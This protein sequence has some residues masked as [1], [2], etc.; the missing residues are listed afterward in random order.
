MHEFLDQ[1]AAS[2]DSAGKKAILGA[3]LLADPERMKNSNILELSNAPYGS[4]GVCDQVSLLINCA[5]PGHLTDI[6]SAFQNKAVSVCS[7]NDPVCDTSEL[8]S[9]LGKVAFDAKKRSALISL[10]LTI[11][12]SYKSLAATT[13]AGK[14]LGRF[15]ARS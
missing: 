6:A 5:S 10:A 12:D 9:Q 2:K 3:V 11:H 8:V 13:T 14:L 4:Y 1:L 7:V 15:I